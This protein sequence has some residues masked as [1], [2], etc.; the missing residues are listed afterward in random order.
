MWRMGSSCLWNRK[1]SGNVIFLED[2]RPQTHHPPT[3][4]PDTL[5]L[6]NKPLFSPPTQGFP[7]NTAATG[8]KNIEAWSIYYWLLLWSI[9]SPQPLHH[10]TFLYV[11]VYWG[12][13]ALFISCLCCLL[14]SH[15]FDPSFTE[16]R[17]QKQEIYGILFGKVCK[18]DGFAWVLYGKTLCFF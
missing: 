17:T 13:R 6:I 9:C 15:H 2:D 14:T 7:F 3:T 16:H 11:A 8:F 12:K 4:P 18:L 10:P 5:F 1:L